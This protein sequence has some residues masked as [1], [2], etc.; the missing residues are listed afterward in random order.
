MKLQL[1]V[2][3]AF[4]QYSHLYENQP[5][6]LKKSIFLGEWLSSSC[7]WAD[8]LFCHFKLQLQYNYNTEGVWFWLNA[9]L[10]WRN[11]KHW[12]HKFVEQITEVDAI[13]PP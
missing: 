12:K 9:M 13:M 5:V 11:M 7:R 8:K 1:D 6:F 2:I 3:S 10:L 4:L